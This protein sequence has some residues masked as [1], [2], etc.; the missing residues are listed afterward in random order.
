MGARTHPTG[1]AMNSFR[2]L[3]LILSTFLWLGAGIWIMMHVIATEPAISG[4]RAA[5]MAPSTSYFVFGIGVVIFAATTL[6]WKKKK[7]DD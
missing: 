1:E 4:E 2:E 7:K 6:F 5:D 3:V